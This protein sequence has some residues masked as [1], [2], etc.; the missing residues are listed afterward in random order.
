M[1]HYSFFCYK[2]LAKSRALH[3][4]YLDPAVTSFR[5]NKAEIVDQSVWNRL[6]WKPS[7]VKYKDVFHQKAQFARVNEHF[8]SLFNADMAEN[9]NSDYQ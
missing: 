5:H 7:R 1:T 9:H 8:E 6:G 4:K 2:I 3:D